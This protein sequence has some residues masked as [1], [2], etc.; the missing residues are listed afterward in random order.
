MLLESASL[1]AIFAAIIGGSIAFNRKQTVVTNEAIWKPATRALDGTCTL[2]SGV[3]ALVGGGTRALSTTIDGILVT[4][5]STAGKQARTTAVATFTP[6]L[7]VVIALVP[8][9]ALTPLGKAIGVVT[10]Q[11]VGDAAF[12]A[13]FVVSSNDASFCRAWLTDALRA[14]L[15]AKD[16]R[17]WEA[18]IENGVVQLEHADAPSS[19]DELVL[20]ARLAA[21][22]ARR[23]TELVGEWE[24][25]AVELAGTLGSGAAFPPIRVQRGTFSLEVT[26]VHANGSSTTRVQLLGG[27]G[28]DP[29]GIDLGRLTFATEVIEAAV[30][31]LVEGAGGATSPYRGA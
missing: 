21:A 31:A 4:V 29:L 27:E 6:P 1:G 24:A 11:E 26:L 15:L 8:E 23:A 20:A 30:T 28:E 7:D 14:K 16:L 2:P 13:C 17:S 10:D 5:R 12:D 25:L 22:L 18:S 3:E 9:A 19:A